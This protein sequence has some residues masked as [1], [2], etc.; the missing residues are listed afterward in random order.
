MAKLSISS[1]INKGIAVLKLSGSLDAYTAMDLERVFD[2]MIN[3]SIVNFLIVCSELEFVSSSGLG[4]LL[5]KL[6]DLEKKNGIIKIS[7]L[8]ESVKRI[9]ELTG[10]SE[11]FD[12]YNSEEE[13]ISS[14][15]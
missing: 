10:C 8:N 9:F 6:G 3:Q 5:I 15:K 1:N 12:V 2:N 11:I 7:G 14:F 13:A 4:V